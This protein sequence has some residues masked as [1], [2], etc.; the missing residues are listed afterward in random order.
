MPDA[1]EREGDGGRELDGRMAVKAAQASSW[2]LFDLP[3]G[4]AFGGP[5]DV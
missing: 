1:P 4:I 2:S 3:L 5:G